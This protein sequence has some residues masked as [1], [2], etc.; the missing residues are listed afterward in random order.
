MLQDSFPRASEREARMGDPTRVKNDSDRCH[1]GL[2]FPSKAPG[3]LFPSF[4]RQVGQPFLA[5]RFRFRTF[6]VAKSIH[7]PWSRTR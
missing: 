3:F 6:T 4:L 7:R 5:V 2:L 1:S